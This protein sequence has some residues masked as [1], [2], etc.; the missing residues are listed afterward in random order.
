VKL[1]MDHWMHVQSRNAEIGI[2][3]ME[4]II[5]LVSSLY[6]EKINHIILSV[7]MIN[8]CCGTPVACC[9][10]IGFGG[11]LHYLY[12]FKCFKVQY[13]PSPFLAYLVFFINNN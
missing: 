1:F 5:L 11:H 6:P 13:L 4:N 7:S 10:G 12:I 3:S 2:H 8:N 9:F